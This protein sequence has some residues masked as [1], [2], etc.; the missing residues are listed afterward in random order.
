MKNEKLVSKEKSTS[1]RSATTE[2]ILNTMKTTV[3]QPLRLP[4]INGGILG[5]G[6][7]RSAIPDHFFIYFLNGHYLRELFN[8]GR[9]NI[10]NKFVT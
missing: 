2:N 9:E 5:N 10:F 4:H 6:R 7:L 8:P 3:Y 1:K